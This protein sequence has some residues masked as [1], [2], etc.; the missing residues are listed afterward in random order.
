M[1]YYC[2]SRQKHVCLVYRT[3]LRQSYFFDIELLEIDLK[4]DITIEI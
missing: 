3:V 1:D 2:Q 4:I